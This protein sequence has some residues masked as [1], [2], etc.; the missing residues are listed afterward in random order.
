MLMKLFREIDR[1]LGEK[2]ERLKN[3]QT[4]GRK[5]DCFLLVFPFYEARLTGREYA[6]TSQLTFYVRE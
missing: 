1:L 2:L 6:R 3:Q 4:T 5:P